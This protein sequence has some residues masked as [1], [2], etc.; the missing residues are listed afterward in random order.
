MHIEWPSHAAS[1]SCPLSPTAQTTPFFLLDSIPE[2]LLAPGL[3]DPCPLHPA[4][5]R[6]RG[7]RAHAEHIIAKQALVPV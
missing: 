4:A 3:G 5:L 2:R 1:P 7:N 6:R